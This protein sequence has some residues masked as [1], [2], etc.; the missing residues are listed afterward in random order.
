MK[1]LAGVGAVEVD[2]ARDELLAGA[3]L[4]QDQDGVRGVGDLG[5]DAVELLHS[6]RAADQVAQAA[7][8][9]QVLAQSA[10]FG[11]EDAALGG[12]LEH[13]VSSSRVKGLVR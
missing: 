1:G 13:G 4:A 9:A 12:A 10:G 2:G 11:I 7:T 5:E 3:A 6:R 8:G